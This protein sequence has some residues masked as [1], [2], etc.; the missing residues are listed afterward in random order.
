M[1]E[2]LTLVESNTFIVSDLNGDVLAG[3]AHGLFFA[4][5]R[6]LSKYNLT[7][8]GQTPDLLTARVVSS[9]AASIYATN[10]PNKEFGPRTL[11]IVRDRFVGD[12]LHEDI[13]V[14]N[15]GP[16]VCRVTLRLDFDADFAD[17]FEVKQG[18]LTLTGE[19]TVTAEPHFTLVF[20]HIHGRLT[21]RTLISFTQTAVIDGRSAVFDIAL[22]PNAHWKTC[23]NIHLAADK[24]SFAPKCRCGEFDKFEPPPKKGKGR[25]LGPA[26]RLSTDND[27]LRHLYERAL[28]DLEA[29]RLDIDGDQAPA[30]GVPWFMTIFGRDSIITSL[31]ALPLAPEMAVG[32]LKTLARHQGVKIDRFRDE[33]PGKI[34]HEIRFGELALLEKVPHARYY[35]TVDA[36]PLWLILLGETY[37]WT[38]DLEL[39]KELIPAA[40]AALDWIDSYGDVDGDGFVEYRRSSSLVNQGWKDSDDAVAFADGRLAEGPI[41]LVEVQGYVYRAKTAMA[42]LFTRLGD[43]AKAGRLNEQAARL[44]KDFN[45]KFWSAKD[46]YFSLALDGQKRLVDSVTSNPGHALWSGIVDRDKASAVAE[47]LMS[48]DM[49]S[50]WG[51]RTLSNKMARYSPLSYHNGSVWPH[52]NS[53]IAA[54]LAAYG[55]N[56]PA[57]RVITAMIEAA[58][59]MPVYRLP[60]LFCGYNRRPLGFPVPYPTASSPQAWATGAVFLFLQALLGMVP[61]SDSRTVRTSPI[62]PTSIKKLA[63][64]I[65]AFDRMFKLRAS[66][67]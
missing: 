12:G 18:E 64:R 39:I 52:D 44:K 10:R 22:A 38:G 23:V 58:G 53:I 54:G 29:L 62:L 51:I 61:D 13:F 25:W 5:T 6:F 17:I 34:L 28:I 27:T 48:D 15:H 50:G 40:E 36:T 31:Q 37:R 2:Q 59:E 26:F 60:E 24:E 20:S 7:L 30:A 1:S 14:H 47:R 56:E 66:R 16:V 57:W 19:T 9:Y 4:D 11:S 63:L 41:A 67:Q 46:D 8:D 35:G 55:F 3:S 42:E 21:R 43:D 49:F 33:E 32:T 65:R 45:N